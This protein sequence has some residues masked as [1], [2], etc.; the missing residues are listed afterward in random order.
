[1]RLFLP[2]LLA[3]PVGVSAGELKKDVVETYA[4]YV[5]QSYSASLEGAYQVLNAIN[6]F[7]AEP[8]QENLEAAR[9]I[10]VEARKVYSKTEVFR[11]Y[12]GPIDNEEN[13]PEGLINAWPLDEAYID[14]V[15]GSPDSGIIQNPEE[16]P[17]ITRELLESLNEKD[18]EKNISTGYHAIE[19]LLWGQDLNPDGPGNRSYKDFV[20]G[21]APFAERRAEYLKLTAELLVYHLEG[22]V[23]AWNLNDADSYASEFVQDEAQSSLEKIFTGV[24]RL[25]GEELSQ[26]R[27]FVAYDTQ[28]QEDEHS[29]FSDTTHFDLLYNFIGIREVM[30]S[31]GA[32]DLIRAEDPV[33][34]DQIEEKLQTAE[35]LI[36]GIP[37][38]FDQ[39]IIDELARPRILEAI[40]A[41]EDIA[42]L[43]KAGV[44][45]LGIVIE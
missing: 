28:L 40:T 10:W 25:S 29:C 22:L 19:F 21:L 24:I 5:A 35:M 12:G 14:G 13:G 23:V 17:E 33:L 37:A 43:T 8:S 27:M 16:Y 2:L 18:G 15:L 4:Q 1:M 36:G 34:A 20:A 45:Q 31:V 26:E 44:A 7:V 38:P 32:L 9:S 11:F 30:L 3:I 39:A 42:L 6:R 41:L